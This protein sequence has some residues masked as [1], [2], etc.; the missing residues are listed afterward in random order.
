MQIVP[1]LHNRIIWTNAVNGDLLG[2][3]AL[4]VSHPD[5]AMLLAQD[6]VAWLGEVNALG[7]AGTGTMLDHLNGRGQRRM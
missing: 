1:G 6:L 4:S 7:G 5:L 2:E 3:V